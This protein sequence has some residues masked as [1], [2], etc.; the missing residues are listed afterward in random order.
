[1]GGSWQNHQHLGRFA[2]NVFGLERHGIMFLILRAMSKSQP[3]I[4][5]QISGVKRHALV[6]IVTWLSQPTSIQIDPRQSTSILYIY[7]AVKKQYI[8]VAFIITRCSPRAINDLAT[9]LF[10]KKLSP[11]KPPGEIL[12]DGAPSRAM[13]FSWLK[14]SG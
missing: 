14:K 3:S 1:M 12:Q 13:A 9:P 4:F 7:I 11:A 2:I 10:S 8:S 5:Q 6:T